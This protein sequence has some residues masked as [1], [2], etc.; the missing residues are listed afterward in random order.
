MLRVHRLVA[1]F[2]R[3]LSCASLSIAPG[4]DDRTSEM[5]SA[6]AIAK[7]SIKMSAAMV[8]LRPRPAAQWNTTLSP[9]CRSAATSRSTLSHNANDCPA[10]VD[11]SAIG[12]WRQAKALPLAARDNPGMPSFANSQSSMKVT[13]SPAPHNSMAARSSA[14]SRCHCRPAPSRPRRPGQFVSP[15]RPPEGR[16][17]ESIRRAPPHM[18]SSIPR[19][20][21]FRF[22]QIRQSTALTRSMEA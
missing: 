6:G 9:R 10:G 18:L 20:S 15:N 4:R 19:F 2:I 12:T 8:P 14:R 22:Q 3:K 16:R 13:T 21:P 5:A 1:T 17:M 11:K 7:R